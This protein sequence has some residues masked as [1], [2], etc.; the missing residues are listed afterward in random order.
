MRITPL[1]IQQKQF[2]RVLR[3]LEPE[4]VHTFLDLIRT[5]FEE[6]VKENNVLKDELRRRLSEI[7][8]YKER[9]RTLKSTMITAQKIAEDIK[10]NAKKDGELVVAEAQVQADRI[11][12]NAHS[13][14]VKIVDEIAELKR[15]RV[16]Y[17]SNLRNL[18]ESHQKLLEVTVEDA[19]EI[20]KEAEKV[21]FL[22]RGKTN[23]GKP[24]QVKKA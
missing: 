13:R 15:Q 19:E 4:D 14:M 21:E 8:E 23:P 5:E 12:N 11:I 24:P 16:Q 7:D 1:D 3:G 6:L 2:K 10:E 18:I 20:T 22:P 9:E 17:E